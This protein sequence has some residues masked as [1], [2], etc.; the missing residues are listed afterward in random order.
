MNETTRT[1]GIE[2]AE[3]AVADLRSRLANARFEKQGRS[4]P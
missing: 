1:F 3:P 2:I 4:V